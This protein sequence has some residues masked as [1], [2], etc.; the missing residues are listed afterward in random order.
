MNGVPPAKRGIAMVFQSYALY[1]HLTV[2]KNMSLALSQEGIAAAEIAV[3]VQKA[4]AML[5]LDALLVRPPA[6][7]SGGQRQR[8]AIGR[9]IVCGRAC[10]CSTPP[11]TRC[12]L[13]VGTRIEI[14][15]APPAR[16]DHDVTM[17]R[18]SHDARRQDRGHERRR[19]RQV[20]RPLELYARPANMFV[21][22]FRHE[23]RLRGHRARANAATIRSARTSRC[24][25]DGAWTGTVSH[26]EHLGMTCSS[27][28]E[29][30][31][32]TA[33]IPATTGMRSGT[34]SADARDARSTASTATRRRSRPDRLLRA[35]VRGCDHARPADAPAALLLLQPKGRR[36]YHRVVEQATEPSGNSRPDIQFL[37]SF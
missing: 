36:R 7:L 16:G 21:A 27:G 24:R 5:P 22:G 4:S 13:R 25:Q 33:R 9:A 14:A 12:S 28:T 6:E 23:F 32:L 26:A 20:G 8:V 30:G 1:P 10:S 11:S 35:P 31:M 2:A 17:T 19:H 37:R 18:S 34:P 29:I 15:A 3:R